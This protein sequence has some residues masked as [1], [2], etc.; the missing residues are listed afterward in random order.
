[1]MFVGRI[2]FQ[3]IS[4]WCIGKRESKCNFVCHR[5]RVIEGAVCMQGVSLEWSHHQWRRTSHFAGFGPVGRYCSSWSL[6]LDLVVGRWL[7]VDAQVG[8]WCSSWLMV[9]VWLLVLKLVVGAQF[10]FWC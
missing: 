8:C 3:N 2:I 4:A 9:H 6:V 5:W 1:M 7:V 10:S